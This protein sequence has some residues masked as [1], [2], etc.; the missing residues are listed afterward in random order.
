[1]PEHND[2]PEATAIVAYDGSPTARSAATV[3]IQIA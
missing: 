3:A 2:I 1:M